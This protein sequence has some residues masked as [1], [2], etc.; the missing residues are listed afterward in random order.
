M[1]MKYQKVFNIIKLTCFEK[2]GDMNEAVFD[3]KKVWVILRLL[4]GVKTKKY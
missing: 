2:V 1:V 3:S 4:L